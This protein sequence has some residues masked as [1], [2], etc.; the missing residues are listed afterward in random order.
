MMLGTLTGTA[1]ARIPPSSLEVVLV[2]LPLLLVQQKTE[3]QVQR[4]LQ[5]RASV[6]KLQ[7]LKTT[8]V[9]LGDCWVWLFAHMLPPPQARGQQER[10]A[11]PTRPR[12]C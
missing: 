2:V 9:P 4:K 10:T 12:S 7:D 11:D 6:I 5:R 8:R 3:K 1:S